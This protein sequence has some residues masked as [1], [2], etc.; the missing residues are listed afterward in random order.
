MKGKDSNKLTCAVFLDLSKAFDT[1]DRNILLKK[2]EHNGIRGPPLKLLTDY[3]NN[4]KQYT[5][6]NGVK[7]SELIIDIGVPQG[8]ILGPLLF[9][10]YINDLPL[11]S[12]LITKLFADDTCLIF[13]S[14][15]LDS[16]QTIIR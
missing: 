13:S 16:L 7:S 1:V 9:L 11:V 6:V 14:D 8:S 10:I 5:L 15:T 3:L 4:R 2:L 12:E